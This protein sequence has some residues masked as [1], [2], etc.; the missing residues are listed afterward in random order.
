MSSHQH[1]AQRRR[2]SDYPRR[3]LILLSMALLAVGSLA[4]FASAQDAARAAREEEG[5]LLPSERIG[6]ESSPDLIDR[7]EQLRAEAFRA[8]MASGNARSASP[9]PESS[10]E[11]VGY[12]KKTVQAEDQE[13]TLEAAGGSGRRDATADDPVHETFRPDMPCCCSPNWCPLNYCPA[14]VTQTPPSPPLRARPPPLF[15]LPTLHLSRC[16]YMHMCELHCTRFL[17][18][19][20]VHRLENEGGRERGR[21]REMESESERGRKNVMICF[22]ARAICMRKRV[23]SRRMNNRESL[24]YNIFT[25]G[26]ISDVISFAIALLCRSFA[27]EAQR[28]L[29]N[30]SLVVRCGDSTP[31]DYHRHCS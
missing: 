7:W 27:V 6:S 16:V 8:E 14:K 1:G 21:G 30:V 25:D 17:L 11:E 2:R 13:A 29:G 4:A 9:P 18:K 5:G 24:I 15:L 19:F 10:T 26:P 22:R 23:L 20:W 12:L 31:A 28:Q 3:G